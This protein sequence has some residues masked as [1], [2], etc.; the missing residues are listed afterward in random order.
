MIRD[1]HHLFFVDLPPAEK[2]LL[3]EALAKHPD[4]RPQAA[5]CGTGLVHLRPAPVPEDFRR[6]LP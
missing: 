4:V 1:G 6:A 2:R 3:D 5:P